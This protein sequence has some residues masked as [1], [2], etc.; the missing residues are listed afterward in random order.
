MPDISDKPF[1]SE[2][3]SMMAPLSSPKAAVVSWAEAEFSS[4]IADK[5]VKISRS[6]DFASSSFLVCSLIVE[7]LSKEL[8]RRAGP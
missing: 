3:I 5:L 1:V 4:E 6:F 8:D 7:I 2:L